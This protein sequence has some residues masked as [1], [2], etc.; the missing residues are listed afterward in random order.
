MSQTPI[1]P[2][3]VEYKQKDWARCIKRQRFRSC[4]VTGRTRV[5]EK[6]QDES[7][8]WFGDDA[9]GE[10]KMIN[11]INSENYIFRS[12]RTHGSNYTVLS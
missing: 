10:M 6:I 5:D 4:T 3:E 1:I 2:I 9:Q 12:H 11:I 7:I 8:V